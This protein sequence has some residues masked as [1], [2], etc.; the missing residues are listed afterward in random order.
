V[1]RRIRRSL[2][3]V[4]ALSALAGTQSSFASLP[5]DTPGWIRQA[6]N[7]AAGS[8][9]ALEFGFGEVLYRTDQFAVANVNGAP[10]KTTDKYRAWGGVVQADG[11]IR[12]AMFQGGQNATWSA[13]Q[14]ATIRDPN[15]TD[16]PFLLGDTVHLAVQFQNTRTNWPA[17]VIAYFDGGDPTA[18]GQGLNGQQAATSLHM[19]ASWDGVRWFDDAP[20]GLSSTDPLITGGA[21]FNAGSLGPTQLFLN[22]RA[23]ACTESPTSNFPFDCQIALMHTA[24]SDTGATSIVLAGADRY[25]PLGSTFRTRTSPILSPGAVWDSGSVDL[26]KMRQRK[27]PEGTGW[28]LTYSGSNSLGGCEMPV[29]CMIGVASSSNRFTWTR[30]NA[31]RAAVDPALYEE[32]TGTP[33]K[34]GPAI[35]ITGGTPEGHA[36]GFINARHPSTADSGDTW[37]ANT[38]PAPTTA[39]TLEVSKPDNGYY[40]SSAIEIDL[41]AND[42]LGANPGVDVDSIE[43]FIDGQPVTQM[44]VGYTVSRSIVGSFYEPGERIQAPAHQL[45]LPD[46][47]HDLLATVADLDGETAELITEFTVDTTP[48]ASVISS[49]STG[50]GFTYPFAAPFTLQGQTVDS[51]SGVE[52]IT[53]VIT[54]TIGQKMVFDSRAEGSGFSLVPTANGYTWTFTPPP[55]L[56]LFVP[57]KL[58]VNI[59]GVDRARNVETPSVNNTRSVIA[60]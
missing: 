51:V 4:V 48:P 25:D 57:G 1:K 31:S 56:G 52:Q 28:E 14:L 32:F 34:L 2:A 38:A 21:G 37:L 5:P 27:L 46:G 30:N 9:P 53:A 58:D 6:G 26:A 13:P 20:L 39:P 17:Y 15:G 8:R 23:N 40:N 35:F 24:I 54:N 55:H 47:D 42:D 10:V 50:N 12:L 44:G 11:S 7:G 36:R 49:M 45:V 33:V 19:A 16:V 60:I 43:L 22:P 18:T 41:F 3:A 29:R 59:L